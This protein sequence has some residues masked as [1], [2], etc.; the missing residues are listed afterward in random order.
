ML[1][2]LF[3]LTWVIATRVGNKPEIGTV[4]VG[5]DGPPVVVN[6]GGLTT[7]CLSGGVGEVGGRKGGEQCDRV[8]N[9]EETL[10]S[11]LPPLSNHSSGGGGNL[12]SALIV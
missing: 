9:E 6:G 3:E 12:F 5:N 11:G 10:S 2:Q 7:R 8:L 4:L 1:S